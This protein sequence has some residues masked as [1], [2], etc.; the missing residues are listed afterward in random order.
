LLCKTS[1]KFWHSHFKKLTKLFQNFV[2][3]LIF[4]VLLY[5][6]YDI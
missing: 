4:F 5:N 2:F 3:F 6:L 1:I